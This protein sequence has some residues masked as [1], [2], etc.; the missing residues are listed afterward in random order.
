[1]LTKRSWNREEDY[2]TLISWW[3]DH[4]FGSVPCDL[5]PPLGV[6]VESDGKPIAAAGLYTCDGTSFGFMDWVVVDP[7]APMRISHKAITLCLDTIIKVAEDKGLK[8]MYTCTKH[9]ALWKRYTKNG[10]SLAEDGVRTFYKDLSGEMTD[11][12]FIIDEERWE[13]KYGGT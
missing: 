2:A 8:L 10:M 5:L 12:E 1:M 6:I 11:F 3:E 4:E 13:E 9:E 7:N